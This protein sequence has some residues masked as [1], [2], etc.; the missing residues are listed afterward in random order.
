MV[1]SKE[2]YRKAYIKKYYKID[3]LSKIK[4]NS[5]KK[6]FVNLS[7]LSIPLIFALSIDFI[8]LEDLNKKPE[9]INEKEI[10]Y[11][12]SSLYN[13]IPK[14]TE[15]SPDETK[16]NKLV[17]VSLKPNTNIFS[18][19]FNKNLKKPINVSIK[20]K[21][22][23][24]SVFYIPEEITEKKKKFIREILPM[25]TNYNKKILVERQIL[26]EINDYLNVNR[27]L[28]K[29]YQKYLQ[30][31]SQTYDVKYKNKHKV[32]IINELLLKVDII[33]NSIVI[34]QAANE[35]GWGTS[36]FAK[37]YNALFGEYTYDDS[38]GVIPLKRDINEKYLI[39]FFPSI[40]KSVESYFN[41]INT[42][43]SYSDFRKERFLQRK[44]SSKFN[45]EL[46]I[47]ELDS[48]ALDQN[49]VSTLKS[50]IKVNRL[51]KLDIIPTI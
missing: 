19:I 13:H 27:T 34:A 15:I 38:A 30:K 25:I 43:F 45:I 23:N 50:I 8:L 24:S 22:T 21:P 6:L 16:T 42:H 35:S 10:N 18:G 20:L 14:L 51:K 2:E 40:N 31:L 33:P 12:S 17:K 44:N 11:I 1:L 36:R 32:D 39:K 41:N 26:Y 48:Y 46:L 3:F 5:T 28:N 29:N 9:I 37:K 49:Y 7:F 47:N 4:I